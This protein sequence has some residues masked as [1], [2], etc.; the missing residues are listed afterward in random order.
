MSKRILL[1]GLVGGV[2]LFFWGF[3]SHA[4]LGLGQ[5]GMRFLPQEQAVVE[6]LKAAVPQRG[7]YYFPQEDAEGKIAPDKAGGPYGILIYHPTGASPMMTGQLINEFI[8]NV[9]QALIAAF[10]LSLAVG[11]TGY[12]SRVGVVFV[13]GVLSGLA[14]NVEYWNWYGFPANYT[15]AAVVDEIIG[16]LVVG[17]I[18]AALVKPATA[19]QAATA[20]AA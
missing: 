1:A 6:P 15:L 2:A 9:I 12:A 8:L 17:L 5:V 10:L 20:K 16:F 13:L 11:L 7:L 14:T 3:L 19:M 4:V 18:V